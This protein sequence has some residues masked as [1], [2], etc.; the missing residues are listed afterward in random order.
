M[1]PSDEDL[2]KMDWRDRY[3]Y[4]ARLE[5][6]SLDRLP[7]AQLLERIRQRRLG[8][9]FG[10]WRV[11]ARKGT[12]QNAALV[13]WDFLQQSPGEANML[14]RYHCAGALFK[15]LGRDDPAS[16][17]ELRKAVQWDH[18]GEAAR[19]EALLELKTIIEQKFNPTAN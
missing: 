2:R 1:S 16:Q 18:H 9:Y 13:L 8:N 7:E 15:I 10:I 17:D 19:Q 11:I 12:L 3:E 14:H 5:D 6:E 4:E